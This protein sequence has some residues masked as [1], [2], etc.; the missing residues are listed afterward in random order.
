MRS[1]VFVAML[2]LAAIGQA[3]AVEDTK[4]SF[5]RQ[6]MPI[7]KASCV[8]CHGEKNPSGK[9]SL[10]SYD[11]LK[12]G[13]QHGEEV[14]AG[15]SGESR[16]V[17]MVTGELMPK[18]PIGG[19]LS[20]DKIALIRKWIDE[21][22]VG[23]AA[24]APQ[25][26]PAKAAFRTNL[27]PPATALAYSPDR[28]LL[29][30]ATYQEVQL[31]DTSTHQ[32][33]RVLAGHE[34]EVQSLAFSPDG[35]FLA[36]GGG[37]PSQEGEIKIWR[38]DSG[39]AV[40]T[41]K[42]HTD[43]VTALAYSPDGKALASG[44]ADKSLRFWDPAAGKLLR[45]V[46]DHADALYAVAYSPD[47]KWLAS[48]G[49]DRT[50]K[51]WDTAGGKRRYTLTGHTD[52]VYALAWSPDSK[53]LASGAAD[54]TVRLWSIGADDGQLVRTLNGHKHT[55]Q[56]LAYTPDGKWLASGSADHTVKLWEPLPANEL[57]TFSE[58][59]DWIYAVAFR[60]DGA[61]LA[62]GA[63]D[64]SVRLWNPAD[65]KLLATLSTSRPTVATR[66]P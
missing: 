20:D 32:R 47:G 3:G 54:K 24:P 64:G 60:G 63:W 50:I 25:S 28:K 19:S 39:L 65:G 52:I 21:G 44:S 57:R 42:E 37:D 17:K 51:L 5:S 45:T 61:E 15:K 12:K 48:S 9:L 31:W 59:A 18:M 23:D 66:R 55:V 29:A 14:V 58:M 53:M 62:A 13:G 16:L 10:V 46:R 27:T 11:A 40:R 26:A 43:V 7:F 4:V 36:A 2:S 49:A 22:A 1:V 35:Q 41:L 6:V 38:L 30:V 33:R 56:A 34:G 8:G